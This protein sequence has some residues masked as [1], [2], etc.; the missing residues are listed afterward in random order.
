VSQFTISIYTRH[1]YLYR[2]ELNANG[3]LS[4]GRSFPQQQLQR[5]V[6]IPFYHFI[7]TTTF[8]VGSKHRVS[9][10]FGNNMLYLSLY[11]SSNPCHTAARPV[12]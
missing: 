11:Q 8:A 3:R 2:G 4:A 1:E 9:G 7:I 6:G 10:R 5:P 12:L